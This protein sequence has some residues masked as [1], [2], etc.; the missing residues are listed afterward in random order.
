VSA[1]LWDEVERISIQLSAES[2]RLI[3]ERDA[4]LAR[5]AKLEAALEP[6]VFTVAVRNAIEYATYAEATGCGNDGCCGGCCDP[7]TDVDL[8]TAR[9]VRETR[10]RAGLEGKEG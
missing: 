3:D 5:V 2:K 6:T 1:E 9:V 8:A 7:S 10:S 4:A